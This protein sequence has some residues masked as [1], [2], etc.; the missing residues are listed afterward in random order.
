MTLFVNLSSYVDHHHKVLSRLRGS[1]PELGKMRRKLQKSCDDDTHG[2]VLLADVF[3]EDKLVLVR[4]DLDTYHNDMVST[5]V[6]GKLH[7]LAWQGDDH[8]YVCLAMLQEHL[9]QLMAILIIG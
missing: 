6:A 1:S 5:W 8:L 3:Y 4:D 7:H 9:H 2:C